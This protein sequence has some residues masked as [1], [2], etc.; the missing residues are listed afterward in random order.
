MSL[1]VKT[2][3]GFSDNIQWEAYQKR[4]KDLAATLWIT[5]DLVYR[6]RAGSE[7]RRER[8]ESAVEEADYADATSQ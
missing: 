4:C 6:N 1:L 2:L 7:I 8:F 3:D 5:D